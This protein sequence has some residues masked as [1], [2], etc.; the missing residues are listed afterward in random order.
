[1]AG[2]GP[3]MSGRGSLLEYLVSVMESLCG[4]WLRAGEEV[5]A[6][7]TLLPAG[8]MRAQ[9]SKPDENWAGAQKLRVRGLR[10]SKAGMPTAA[11]TDEIL[12]PGEG[13]VRA[14]ISW[15]GNPAVAFPDQ[16]RTERALRSLDLFVQ[17]DPWYTQ[18]AQLADYVLAPTL[19]LE[20]PSTTVFLDA[21]SGR[22][23]GYGLSKSY[24][25]Y[26]PAVVPMPTGSDLLEEWRIFDGLLRRLGYPVRARPFGQGREQPTID[27]PEGLSTDDLLELLCVNPRVSLSTVKA[28][29]GGAAFPEGRAV[30]ESAGADAEWLDIGHPTMMSSLSVELDRLSAIGGD[31]DEEFPFKLLCRRENYVYNTSHNHAITNRGRPYNP[32]FLHPFDLRSLGLQDGDVVNLV[33]GAG[34]I[35]AV[36]M[37]DERLLM[38]T[39]SMAFG[40][41]TVPGI[42]GAIETHG[43]SP[44]RLVSAEEFFDPFTG[45]PRMTNVPVRVDPAP[46]GR[47][48]AHDPP[49]HG[50][51]SGVGRDR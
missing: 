8:R 37:S 2:T 30:V 48:D 24:A 39:V 45:Q 35:L 16:A 10:E 18:S 26:S 25:Q 15:G 51:R 13:Q 14:L 41:G 29:P 46:D 33:S 43:S 1:M 27:V 34:S 9:A 7:P 17:I 23:T 50:L 5:K 28:Y 36:V 40:Y 12:M 32:A 31:F 49:P 21:L 4:R 20:V 11:L 19:P 42:P 47:H 44:S 3:N 6:T 22:A 38:G